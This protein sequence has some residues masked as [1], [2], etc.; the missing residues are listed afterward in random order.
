VGD[1]NTDSSE[2]SELG[3]PRDM[4]VG[5][6]IRWNNGI[7]C[8]RGKSNIESGTSGGKKK[9]G[10]MTKWGCPGVTEEWE[11]FSLGVG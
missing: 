4:R 10:G 11:S 3:T 1:W 9:K 6:K 2:A 8:T 5:K 7:Y